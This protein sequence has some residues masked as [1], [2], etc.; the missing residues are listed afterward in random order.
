MNAAIKQVSWRVTDRSRAA[1][2]FGRAV[3]IGRPDFRHRKR[4]CY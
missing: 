1:I 4:R 3:W 2:I